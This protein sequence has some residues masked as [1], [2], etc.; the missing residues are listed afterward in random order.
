MEE[1]LIE[2]LHGGGHPLFGNSSSMRG[3]RRA[4]DDCK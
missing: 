4:K 3:G 2:N 1:K